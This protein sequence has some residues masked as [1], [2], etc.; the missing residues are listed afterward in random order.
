MG[1]LNRVGVSREE[2]Q[3]LIERGAS[4]EELVAY[5]DAHVAPNRR[6]EANEYVLRDHA[7]SLAAQDAEEGR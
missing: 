4:D 2:F 7:D 3:Q 5:F 1:F 6:A